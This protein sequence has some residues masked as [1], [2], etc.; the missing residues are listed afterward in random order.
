VCPANA[1]AAVSSLCPTAAATVSPLCPTAAAAVFSLCPAAAAPPP[2]VVFSALPGGCP[3]PRAAARAPLA[4]V[5][6]G[7]VGRRL[8]NCGE[9]TITGIH[10]IAQ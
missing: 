8:R 1:A 6:V 3:L 7:R 5:W 10:N 9:F 4:R 2:L